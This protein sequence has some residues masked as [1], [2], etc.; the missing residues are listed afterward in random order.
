MLGVILRFAPKALL[1]IAGLATADGVGKQL[2][3]GRLSEEATQTYEQAFESTQKDASARFPRVVSLVLKDSLLVVRAEIRNRRDEIQKRFEARTIEQIGKYWTVTAMRMSDELQHTR[4]ELTF[5]K[6]EYDVGLSAD[7][8]SRRE[9]ERGSG[10]AA[11]QTR[12]ATGR[13]VR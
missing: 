8:L 10:L 12:P 3:A 11:A 1:A 4:T 2:Q 6:V 13:A 5:D 9:L 7:D